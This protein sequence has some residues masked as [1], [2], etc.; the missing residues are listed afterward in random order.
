M[1][2][3]LITEPMKAT[4]L[5]EALIVGEAAFE[6]LNRL[7]YT[8][9]PLSDESRQRDILRR[10]KVFGNNTHDFKVTDTSTGRIIAVSR[11]SP[12]EEE[13][14]LDKT[15]EEVVAE[16]LSVDIP[17]MRK[18]VAARVWTVINEGKRAILGIVDD[19]GKVVRMRK[20]F[21]LDALYVHPDYQR[22]GVARGLLE[23]G[24]AE[25]ERLG[26]PVYL[27]A[28]VAGR[29]VYERSGFEALQV[30]ELDGREFGVDQSTEVTVC[31]RCRSWLG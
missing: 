21:E 18:D 29:P 30:A 27:E 6:D 4:D 23:W 31:T 13:Q 26:L 12:Y 2:S 28:T 19:D 16:R 24:I 17:E 25:A 9:T 1:A 5:E 7:V 3:T 14:V 8:K 20:R 15:V 10:T 11:W 22:R